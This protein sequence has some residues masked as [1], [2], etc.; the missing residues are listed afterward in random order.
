MVCTVSNADGGTLRERLARGE[1]PRVTLHAE[2]D[3]GWRKT[4]ILVAELDGPADADGPF[5][6]FSGHHDTWYF[7]VMDNGAA[8]ATM[9]EVARLL[10]ARPRAH[11]GA[12]CGCASGPAIRTAAIP[13]PP[14][15]P[16]ST[17]T[18]WNAAVPCT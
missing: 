8:N 10:A 14:G 11:G 13:A 3:T 2:V 6:L 9:L 7:G 18:N 16:T 17:G 12:A 5:V 1:Q 4:P 15:M